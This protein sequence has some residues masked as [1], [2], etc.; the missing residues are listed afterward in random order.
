M[1]YCP[2]TRSTLPHAG[3]PPGTASPSRPAP[4]GPGRLILWGAGYGVDELLAALPWR[5]EV[6]VRYWG[7]IDTHGYAILARVRAVAPHAT[8][9]LMDTATLL[10][11]RPYWSTEAT[12][13][14][15]RLTHLAA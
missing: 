10:A 7:D 13:R 2:P 5:T 15:D 9:V 11:H 3:S 12:P 6:A 8:S 14:T 4:T 1:P